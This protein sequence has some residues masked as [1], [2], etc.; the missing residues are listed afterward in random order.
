MLTQAMRKPLI[1]IPA[2]LVSLTIIS[3]MFLTVSTQ[4]VSAPRACGGCAEFK[5]LTNQFEK[6]VLDAAVDNPDSIPGLLE[7]YS[8]NVLELFPSSPSP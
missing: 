7:Q 5:K 1:S 4:Q 3:M 8:R 2:I 6:D